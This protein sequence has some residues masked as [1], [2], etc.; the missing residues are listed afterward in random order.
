MSYEYWPVEP[1]DVF[2]EELNRPTL[3]HRFSSGEPQ[4]ATRWPRE[5]RRFTLSWSNASR[6]EVEIMRAFSYA[7]TGPAELFLFAHHAK[8]APPFAGPVLSKALGG[9]SESGRV[10]YVR[11]TWSD[12]TD[13]T[14]PSAARSITVGAGLLVVAHVPFFPAGAV[15]A[16][17][18][19]GANATSMTRQ[20]NRIRNSGVQWTEPITGYTTGGAALPT[21]NGLAED[22]LVRLADASIAT[23]KQFVNSYA[24]QV[25][26]NEVFA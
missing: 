12:G 9:T 3:S 19:C 21:T 25:M 24:V 1:Q 15:E 22:V 10:V 8:V 5:L 11:Y 2:V 4:L 23:T 26:L 7:H 13:E 18:Y 20:T 16:R 6:S 17:I 14:T